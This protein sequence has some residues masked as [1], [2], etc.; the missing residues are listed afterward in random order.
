M[1]TT[2]ASGA[3]ARRRRGTPASMTR[4]ASASSMSPA[5]A[6]VPSTTKPES[7]LFNHVGIAARR[8]RRSSLPVSSNGV[9]RGARTPVTCMVHCRAGSDSCSRHAVVSVGS[10]SDTSKH[11]KGLGLHLS[12]QVV[13]P[14]KRILSL[15]SRPDLPAK[16][17]NCVRAAM[18]PT[19]G[20]QVAGRGEG[21]A[22][23]RR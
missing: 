6:L 19:R 3:G 17:E 14:S 13:A 2:A 15:H 7:G 16:R 4:S 23:R 1:A 8:R 12:G 10:A 5:A 18:C 9:G 11:A 22:R 21:H 20:G